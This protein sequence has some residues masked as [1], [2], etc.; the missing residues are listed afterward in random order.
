[1]DAN[2]KLKMLEVCIWQVIAVYSD[3]GSHCMI[4]CFCKNCYLVLYNLPKIMLKFYLFLKYV[5]LTF[6]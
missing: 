4:H 1:M 3:L 2:S 5:F 6:S